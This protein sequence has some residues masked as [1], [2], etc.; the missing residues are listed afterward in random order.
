MTG[1]RRLARFGAVRGLPVVGRADGAGVGKVD[2]VLVRLADLRTIGFR[3]RAPGFWSGMLGVAAS[4]VE[5][6]GRDYVIV[7]ELAAAEPA[8][9]SR[10]P[11]DDRVWWSEW[12]GCHCLTRRGAEVGKLT[13]LIL[14]ADA[15]CARALVLE[16]GRL[17]VPGPRVA[18][19][20][21]SVIVDEAD[22]AVKL[23]GAEDSGDWWRELEAL[24]P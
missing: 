24:L 3:L 9:E 10:G 23:T 20:A 17:L 4:S 16:G 22:V 13:D 8:G 6:L 2:D 12:A 21:D 7:S 19:G 18:I 11:L 1:V 14:D 5:R 15:A